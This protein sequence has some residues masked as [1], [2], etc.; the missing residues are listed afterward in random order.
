MLILCY[1]FDESNDDKNDLCLIRE[2]EKR[3]ESDKKLAFICA[4]V[5]WPAKVL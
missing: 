2:E 3:K 1:D 4:V 5:E